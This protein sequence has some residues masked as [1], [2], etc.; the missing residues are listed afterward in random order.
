MAWRVFWVLDI[1]ASLGK[2]LIHPNIFSFNPFT[3]CFCLIML[4]WSQ[5]TLV[6]NG[7]SY[8][9]SQE[10]TLFSCPCYCINV[11]FSFLTEIAILIFHP[12]IQN[13]NI[14]GGLFLFM[15]T[16][17]VFIL[18]WENQNFILFLNF[19]WDLFYIR[20]KK[21]HPATTPAAPLS[22]SEDP[23]W[24]LKRNGL[25]SS[26]QIFISSIGKTYFF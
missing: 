14:E 3:T 15:L 7:S 5:N 2:L 4:T 1:H 23:T 22:R 26:G 21:Y 24:F 20:K 18:S 9:E 11:W 10:F 17:V 13:I 16:W 25:E 12:F 19:N 6:M 8:H